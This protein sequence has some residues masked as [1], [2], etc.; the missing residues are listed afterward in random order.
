MM[1]TPPVSRARTDDVIDEPPTPGPHEEDMDDVDYESEP[2]P[3]PMSLP[4]PHAKAVAYVGPISLQSRPS[5]PAITRIRSA[6]PLA[7]P[8][9][10]TREPATDPMALMQAQ[11]AK[12]I[13]Q[14]AHRET[15]CLQ[16]R[17][18]YWPS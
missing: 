14:D 10:I 6:L 15:K 17:A 18:Q 12:L 4:K 7:L 3:E 1:S 11:L 8:L 9:P 13:A 2:E 5:T 16:L